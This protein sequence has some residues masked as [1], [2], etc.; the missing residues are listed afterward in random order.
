MY[1]WCFSN[2][3]IYFDPLFSWGWD[4]KKEKE[5]RQKGVEIGFSPVWL[6]GE[7]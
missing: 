5:G 4:V 3:I 1:S 7:R 6:R 2:S